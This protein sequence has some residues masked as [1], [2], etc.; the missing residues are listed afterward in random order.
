MQFALFFSNAIPMVAYLCM[1]L[2]LGRVYSPRV[3][4][5][6]RGER[7]GERERARARFTSAQGNPPHVPG[8]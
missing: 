8:T 7:E 2:S 6:T 1:A 5:L 4:R 3:F